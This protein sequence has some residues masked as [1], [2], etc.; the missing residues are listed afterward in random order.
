MCGKIFFSKF[1]NKK[2]P[3]APKLALEFCNR[4]ALISWANV[5][6]C[7]KSTY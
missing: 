5:F 3:Q 2:F 7:E 6:R 4:C 1:P